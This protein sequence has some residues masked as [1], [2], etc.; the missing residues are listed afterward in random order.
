MKEISCKKRS[1]M[2]IPLGRVCKAAN[3]SSV[4]L[5]DT[6]SFSKTATNIFAFHCLDRKYGAKG[7]E[8]EQI[9]ILITRSVNIC[10]PTFPKV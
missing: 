4:H 8:T 9:I 3:R 5:E 6:C 10:C 1:E 2:P 7:Q